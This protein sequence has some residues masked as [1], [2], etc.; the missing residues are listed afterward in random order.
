MAGNDGLT[1]TKGSSSTFNLWE[2]L[3]SKATATATAT[4]SN[5][6]QGE[7]TSND[8]STALY[9]LIKQQSAE[10]DRPRKLEGYVYTDVAGYMEYDPKTAALNAYKR[11]ARQSLKR[12]AEGSGWFN[13]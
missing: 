7:S 5:K 4:V 8:S 12:H 11:N 3:F 10:I 9:R 6:P 2:K 1:N 13:L